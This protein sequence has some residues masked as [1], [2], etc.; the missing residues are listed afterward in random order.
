MDGK[1][2]L[3]SFLQ[4][5]ENFSIPQYQR[6]YAWGERNLNEL[7]EDLEE[8]IEAK[9]QNPE[10]GGHFLGTIVIASKGQNEA[11]IIDGQQR[12]STLF[13]ILIA[14]WERLSTDTRE[15]YGK[16]ILYNNGE[17]KLQVA[18]NNQNFFKEI[19]KY[20]KNPH[21]PSEKELEKIGLKP[22]TQ[23]QK[24]YYE[25]FKTLLGKVKDFDEQG[26]KQYFE[27]LLSM[28]LI[29][30]REKDAGAAIR[31]FQS[32][33][34]RGVPLRLLDKLKSLLIYYSNRFC[35]DK[36]L[37]SRINERFGEIF[38]FSME[39]FSHRYRSAIFAT[40][41]NEIDDIERDIFRYHLASKVFAAMNKNLGLYK[42]SAEKHYIELKNNIKSINKENLRAF[43]EDYS[44]DLKRFFKA[45]RDML[46]SIDGDVAMFKALIIENINPMYYNTFVRLKLDN[47][48]DDEMITLFT[49]ADCVLTKLNGKLKIPYDFIH[50]YK[51]GNIVELK[52]RIYKECKESKYALESKIDSFVDDTFNQTHKKIFHYLFIEYNESRWKQ[53]L[54]IGHLN[55]L[56][57]NEEGREGRQLAQTIEHIISQS[58]LDNA[59]D[60]EQVAVAMALIK[61]RGFD[62]IEDLKKSI[63]TYGNLLSLEKR[64]NSEASNNSN[65]TKEEAYSKSALPFVQSFD[66]SKVNR[67]FIIDCNN[68]TKKWLKNTFFKDF[69]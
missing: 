37:D 41:S 24:N 55:K 28:R 67:Q 48:L 60:K 68:A 14:L 1:G 2:T 64:Y 7:W 12:L 53:P 22:H 31:T 47:K 54:D 6:D 51:N 5:Y 27:S 29:C 46:N 26:A 57:Q 36:E 15:N 49:K 3:R 61:E 4:D 66:P 35:A 69:L 58:V 10:N 50:S 25:V 38:A 56:L 32:V 42:E 33:N 21:L 16:N 62:N 59:Q 19:L 20:A 45:V 30:F 43:L 18:S 34:D 40:Q 39:I 44:E 11:D 8:N 63:N 52:E 65:T 23:G 9:A 17:C 13:M